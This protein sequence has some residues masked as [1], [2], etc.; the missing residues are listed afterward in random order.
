MIHA[1]T[2]AARA[3]EVHGPVEEHRLVL[4][5]IFYLQ[6]GIRGRR[7]RKQLWLEQD[8]SVIIQKHA[9]SWLA[10]GRVNRKLEA[11]AKIQA[12]MDGKFQRKAYQQK[13]SCVSDVTLIQRQFRLYVGRKRFRQAC[14]A[15]IRIA[16]IERGNQSRVRL[17]KQKAAAITITQRAHPWLAVRKY[18]QQ[19]QAAVAIQG[20]WRKY[21]TR[22][23]AQTSNGAATKISKYWRRYSLRKKYRA[24]CKS[25]RIIFGGVIMR[26]QV[27]VRKCRVK[28]ATTIAAAWRSYCVR[29][30]IQ[31]MGEAVR[32]IQRAFHDMDMR[33]YTQNMAVKI[34]V[35][36]KLIREAYREKH[37]I[38]IQRFWRIWCRRSTPSIRGLKRAVIVLQSH[39]RRKHAMKFVQQYRE[40]VGVRLKRFV[41]KAVVLFPDG[42][43]RLTQTR[44][45]NTDDN[46]E[47]L[48]SSHRLLNLVNIPGM[49]SSQREDLADAITPIQALAKFNFRVKRVE[50]IQRYWRAH[51]DYRDFKIKASEA[52]RI[53]TFWRVHL[54]RKRFLETV[55]ATIKM[56]AILQKKIEM[57]NRKK[58]QDEEIA[59]VITAMGD[60][61][62]DVVDGRRVRSGG[63]VSN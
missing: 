46:V 62:E 37:G 57:K 4:E 35:E 44:E 9:R 25:A 28:A 61:G 56:Q 39:Y 52:K 43:G 55:Q 16:R 1:Y 38:V 29:L 2:L 27:A 22:D 63:S 60:L 50:D 36:A 6:R 54:M 49:S 23:E 21:L 33:F 12:A 3:H 11:L 58:K 18:R 24:K 10:K 5:S 31:L 30:N 26:K 13:R 51:L 59:E 47:A 53:Q 34:L 14:A 20:R 7:S 32:K 17:Q 48:P 42:K 19:N 45:I 15:Q 40:L 8:V 41:T